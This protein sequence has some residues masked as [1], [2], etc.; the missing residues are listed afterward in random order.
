MGC[1]PGICKSSPESVGG[2]R[3]GQTGVRRGVP[4]HIRSDNGKLRDELLQR[5]AFDTLLEANGALRA[6]CEFHPHA[7]APLRHWNTCPRRLQAWQPRVLAWR[8][9]QETHGG[10][11]FEGQNP[12][13]IK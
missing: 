7:D 9:P 3:A 6:P 10:G 5:E 1:G 4:D 2:P 11:L 13:V 8:V 12:I